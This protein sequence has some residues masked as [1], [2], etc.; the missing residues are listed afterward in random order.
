M[1]EHQQEQQPSTDQQAKTSNEHSCKIAQQQQQP[2]SSSCDEAPSEERKQPSDSSDITVPRAGTSAKDELK[3]STKTGNKM[4]SGAQEQIKDPI[5]KNSG[6]FNDGSVQ[7]P[8]SRIGTLYRRSPSGRIIVRNPSAS[9]AHSVESFERANKN[10]KQNGTMGIDKGDDE[11]DQEDV[12]WGQVY[13][14]CC[15]HS[16]RE[17][18]SIALFALVLLTVLYLFLVGLDLLSTGFKVAQ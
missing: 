7:K 5:D 11:D 13:R 17:W 15:C 16:P 4:A 6:S 3:E 18:A 8:R 10:R 9:K 1:T 2:S 14:T 12:T